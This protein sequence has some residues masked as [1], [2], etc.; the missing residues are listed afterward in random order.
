M[1]AVLR[2]H[3]R[4]VIHTTTALAALAAGAVRASAQDA[5]V[6]SADSGWI[7]AFVHWERGASFVVG[8]R[9]SAATAAVTRVP[10]TNALLSTQET[11]QELG[12]SRADGYAVLTLLPAGRQRLVIAAEG[13]RT[14]QC[15]VA[16]RA[17][18]TD[19]LEVRL[20]STEAVPGFNSNAYG[21]RQPR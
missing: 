15:R 20:V 2:Q 11:K 10:I 3:L 14:L 9:Q 16:V 12:R 21:C 5:P 7:V 19:T 13:Y 17:G 8:N 4:R 6:A 1:R 18:A